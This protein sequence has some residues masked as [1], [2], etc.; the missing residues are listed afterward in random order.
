MRALV[1]RTKLSATYAQRVHKRLV[2]FPARSAPVGQP[3]LKRMWELRGNLTTYDAAYVAL[4]ESLQATTGGQA[5]LITADRRL[6]NAPGV[7]CPVLLYAA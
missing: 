3:L 4:A 1:G 5:A 6:A 7:T 2:E